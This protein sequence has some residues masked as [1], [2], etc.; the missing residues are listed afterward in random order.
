[1]SKR[2]LYEINVQKLNFEW[3]ILNIPLTKDFVGRF[4]GEKKLSENSFYGTVRTKEVN[5]CKIIK[6]NLVLYPNLRINSHYTIIM[7]T[8]N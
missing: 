7:Y 8:L 2:V 6:L 1:M 4:I 5:E 3:D